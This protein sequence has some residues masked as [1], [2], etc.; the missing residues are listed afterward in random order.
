MNPWAILS[1]GWLFHVAN[2]NQSS[3]F[4]AP[5]PSATTRGD[6]TFLPQIETFFC[7]LSADKALRWDAATPTEFA[8]CFKTTCVSHPAS[9]L[10]APRHTGMDLNSRLKRWKQ[11]G[12][13]RMKG[14]CLKTTWRGDWGA[15]KNRSDVWN[16]NSLLWL[17]P[18]MASSLQELRAARSL[19]LAALS[20]ITRLL[21]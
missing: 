14:C 12:M 15:E 18:H 5:N 16:Y 17:T 4:N 6:G 2:G 8:A 1:L 20:F 7:L 19:L 9:S 13:R 11:R 3:V 21:R 10:A